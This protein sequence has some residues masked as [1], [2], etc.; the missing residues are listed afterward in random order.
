MHRSRGFTYV[1]FVVV[2]ALIVALAG[3]ITP[4]VSRDHDRVR[5]DRATGDVNRIASAIVRYVGDTSVPPCGANGRK[6]FHL[7][8]GD[9]RMP[10]KNV[11]ASGDT[12]PLGAFLAENSYGTRDWKGPYLAA[13]PADPWGSKYL[14]NVEGYFNSRE[15]VVVLSAGPNRTIET[16]P[17]AL[18]PG[19]DDIAVIVP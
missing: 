7:L 11:F 3:V 13:I 5:I 12:A 19:G 16:D 8:V 10:Q 6:S 18:E 17:A 1:S 2:V 4:Y 15:R 9:G 14:V